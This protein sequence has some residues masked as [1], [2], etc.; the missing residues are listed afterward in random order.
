MDAACDGDGDHIERMHAALTQR[1]ESDD[2]DA[3][4]LVA[5]KASTGVDCRQ[6]QVRIV[7]NYTS[8]W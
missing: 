8:L 4:Y 1:A 3:E 6:D 2:P 5:L 7:T